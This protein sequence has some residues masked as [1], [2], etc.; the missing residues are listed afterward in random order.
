MNNESFIQMKNG[1]LEWF[2]TLDNLKWEEIF[3]S[4]DLETY[5]I[6]RDEN[7]CISDFF[8]EK[9]EILSEEG[10]TDARD[11][12]IKNKHYE[13]MILLFD[14]KGWPLEIN[15]EKSNELKIMVKPETLILPKFKNAGVTGEYDVIL[16]FDNIGKYEITILR[17]EKIIPFLR[18]HVD[19]FSNENCLLNYLKE[20]DGL[21]EYITTD[22][23]SDSE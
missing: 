3:R 4:M 10:L 16:Y 18:W 14:G 23:S 11:I 17:N 7:K 21:N 22:S 19:V 9:L 5:R 12:A 15:L 2:K 13:C 1:N 20:I 8:H 6:F